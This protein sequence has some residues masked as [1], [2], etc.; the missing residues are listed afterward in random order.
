MASDATPADLSHDAANP[1]TWPNSWP[2]LSGFADVPDQLT[3]LSLTVIGT[4]PPYAVGT[5]YRT[6]PGTYTLPSPPTAVTHWFD[7]P[8]HL[9]SFR[10]LSPTHITHTSRRT[11]S[12][13]AAP[14][15][16]IT[17]GQRAPPSKPW[18]TALADLGRRALD[19]AWGDVAAKDPRSVNVSVAVLPDLPGLPTEKRSLYTT[20]DAST[21]LRV[22]PT[23]LSPL[24]LHPQS[25][26]HP[27]LT[28]PLTAAHPAR[29]PKTGD[30]FNYNL[31]LVPAPTYRVFRTSPTTGDTT[32]LASFAAPAA[33]L[34]S[35]FLTEK[36]VVVCVW[37]S[38][39][40]VNGVSILGV[41]NLADAMR[42]EGR[43]E[44]DAQWH[45]IDRDG[46]GHAGCFNGPGFF[47]F[48][49]VN[50]WDTPD[51]DVVA[52]VAAYPSRAVV[53][54]FYLHRL[55]GPATEPA[56]TRLTRFRIPVSGG[57]GGRVTRVSQAEAAVSP[58]LPTINPRYATREH[59]YTY[60]V[61]NRG[62]SS[63]FDGLVKV[64]ARGEAKVWERWGQTPGEGVFISSDDEE[65]EED[66][67]VLV[68]L[69]LDGRPGRGGSYLL[70]LDARTMEEVARAGVGGLKVGLGFHGVHIP[71]VG[72]WG[73]DDEEGDERNA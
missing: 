5:L 24:S 31:A 30:V 38:R 23:T 26:L 58:E 12:T 10:I 44:E 61:L 51:G 72:A 40:A 22:S 37:S 35:I 8:G 6:G 33:W 55:R 64:D 62:R 11:C 34:H 41:G 14:G 52:E 67:G 65:A 28:G 19:A 50:A 63:L 18:S 16:A 15:S 66:E 20:T 43:E 39:F 42:G 46:G 3:P 29:C 53:S 2:N 69:V 7:G 49:A 56:E 1:D 17:F 36:Y 60:G 71:A 13:P 68:S 21:L 54:S 57:A 25:A 27:S 45:V 59:R 73:F 70:F 47:A 9:H 4:I 48:H 32:L